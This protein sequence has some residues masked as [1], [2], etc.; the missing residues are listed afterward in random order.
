MEPRFFLSGETLAPG[1]SDGERRA[2]VA[3][4]IT[5]PTNEWFAKA[6]VNRIWGE[7]LGEGFTMPID[8]MGPDR[9][10]SHPEVLDRLAKGFTASGY[11]P[12]WLLR[13]ITATATYQRSLRARSVSDAASFASARPSRLRGDAIYDALRAALGLPEE[14]P[15]QPALGPNQR[16][17]RDFGLRAQVTRLFGFDPSTPQDELVGT[18]PQALFL[19]NNPQINRMIA[20][21]GPTRLAAILRKYADNEDALRE[22]YLNVLS[23]EPSERELQVGLDYIQEVGNRTEAFEDLM[24]ALLNSAEFQSRR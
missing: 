15:V 3:A 12:K 18:V 8:D 5:S 16:F 10:V 1:R 9:T 23:R 19:M 24:W 21:V 13:T 14:A 20:G 7:L 11:S 2:A 22:L 4:A 6:Y 17:N